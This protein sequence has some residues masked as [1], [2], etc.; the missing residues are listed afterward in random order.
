MRSNPG[1]LCKIYGNTA[2]NRVLEVCL[3]MKGA[4]FA[5]GD[6]A[7]V[8]EVSRPKAYQ[9]MKELENKGIVM[10]TRIVGRTQLY[11]L[12]IENKLS[13]IFLRNFNEASDISLEEY[14]KA[15]PQDYATDSKPMAVA[16]KKAA[17]RKS[18]R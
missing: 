17:Y 1:V 11:A 13:K 16:E 10:E 18:K 7:A 3:A 6:M 4:D 8:A 2:R 12:N 15:Y 9:I 14:M 5:I